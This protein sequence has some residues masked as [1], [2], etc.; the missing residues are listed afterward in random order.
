MELFHEIANAADPLNILL[1]LGTALL[2]GILGG[3]LL[4]LLKM[5]SVVGYIISGIVIGQ[6]GIHFIDGDTIEMLKPYNYFALGII[7]FLIGGELKWEVFKKYGKQ[8]TNI[9][10]FEALTAF[11][12]VASVIT[13]VGSFFMP[14]PQAISI[15][16]VLGAIASATAPAATTDVLWENK[17]RGPITR[18]IM[19]LVALDDALALILF[20]IAVSVAKVLT[21]NGDAN[22]LTSIVTPVYEMGSAVLIG[23]IAGKSLTAL[24]D[25][26]AEEGA[27]LRI[28]IGVLLV[29]LGGAKVIQ[30]DMLLAAMAMGATLS[31][32]APR[33]SPRIFSAIEGITPP[34]FVI[35]FVLVGAGL[36]VSGLDT[37]AL[38]LVGAYFLGR[39]GGKMLGA[40]IGAKVGRAPTSVAKYLRYCLF[41]QAGVAIGLSIMAQ[42][43]FQDSFGKTIAIVI[44]TSTFIVQLIGPALTKYAVTKGGEVGLNITEEDLLEKTTAGRICTARNTI[45]E[46]TPVTKII[47]LFSED[48]QLYYPVMDKH[49]SVQGVVTIQ[50]IKSAFL[51]YEITDFLL[52]HDLMEQIHTFAAAGDR[53]SDVN[54]YISMDEQPF[55]IILSDSGDYAGILTEQDIQKYITSKIT[56]MRKIS[57]NLDTAEV[58]A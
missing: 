47:E 28:S 45:T 33:K 35:F 51:A 22:I 37:T 34:V 54:S 15:G 31:N 16:L 13:L 24:I 29:I 26:R 6:T 1:L 42:D 19:G 46:D 48:D 32:S 2:A 57:N 5:P 39:T 14:F 11:V 36:S 21:G 30:S 12:A 56:E 18:T 3:R 20:A 9:L 10:L 41:S 40:T 17:T 53:L 38:I 7:G 50:G 55:A 44:T 23:I 4:V 8:F 52:A 25:P 43:I 49:H 58:T 27:V